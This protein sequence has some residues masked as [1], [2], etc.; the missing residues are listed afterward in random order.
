MFDF[1]LYF[2]FSLVRHMDQKAKGRCDFGAHVSNEALYL[3]TV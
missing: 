2:I 1:F 3:F